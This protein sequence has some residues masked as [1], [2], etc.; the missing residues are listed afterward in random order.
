MRSI[1]CSCLQTALLDGPTFS[2]PSGVI[3]MTTKAPYSDDLRPALACVNNRPER[4]SRWPERWMIHRPDGGFA[5]YLVNWEVRS[6][7]NFQ[8]F[9]IR[10]PELIVPEVVNAFTPP[11]PVNKGSRILEW[12]H[13]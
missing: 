7:G 9:L 3:A 13:Q 6:A 8:P 11:R 4:T 1:E 2:V 12:L 10:I 5:L